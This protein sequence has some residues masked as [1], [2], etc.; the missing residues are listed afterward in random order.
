MSKQTPMYKALMTRSKQSLAKELEEY[1]KN[2]NK[3]LWGV[4]NRKLI[5][6]IGAVL[7]QLKKNLKED[8]KVYQDFFKES[9]DMMD[10]FA[11]ALGLPKFVGNLTT[12]MQG[13]PQIMKAIKE[14]R[15]L[16]KHSDKIKWT[17][18]DANKWNK[19]PIVKQLREV[20]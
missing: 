14:H 6:Q 16:I 15:K 17:V 20:K 9:N 2:P 7:K 10:D 4:S 1:R 13:Y 18:K 11:K 12:H 19:H 3:D 5:E 8:D